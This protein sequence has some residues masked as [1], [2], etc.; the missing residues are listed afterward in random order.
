MKL[1][2]DLL[3]SSILTQALITVIILSMY[4]VL[5]IMGNPI[6]QLVEFLVSLVVSFYFGSKIGLI[7]GINQ[8]KERSSKNA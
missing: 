7:Q 6:P 3:K 4:F 8:E 1:L 2:I 5:L